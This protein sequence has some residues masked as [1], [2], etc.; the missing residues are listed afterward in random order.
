M[1][2]DWNA[3]VGSQEILGVTGRFCIGVQNKVG[4]RLTE[5]CQEN[6]LVIA[7]TFFQQHKRR[8]YTWRSPDGQHWLIDW[9]MVNTDWLYSL[10]PKM[11]KLYKG[12]KN[13][14]GSWLWPRSWTPYCEIQKL[15]KVG[16]TIRPFSS[17]QFSSVAQSCPTL[18]DPMN[19]STP[20]LPVHHRLLEFIH[21]HVHW[22]SDAIQPSHPLPSPSPSALN[23]FQHQSLFQWV[24]P[25]HQVAKILE[26]QH[27]SFPWTFR[28]DFL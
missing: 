1:I 9:L 28:T 26:F 16:E 22:V 27:Q 11:E 24:S 13:K 8:L 23:L 10:Q 15:K 21:T 3:K 25:S 5:F 12:S 14:T 2:R 7:N 17:V 18:C 19:R 6:T 4:Q 20:G